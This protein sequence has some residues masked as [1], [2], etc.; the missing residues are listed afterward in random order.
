MRRAYEQNGIIGFAQSTDAP[1]TQ[2]QISATGDDGNNDSIPSYA[3]SLYTL[4]MESDMARLA[5]TLVGERYSVVLL[6]LPMSWTRFL[7]RATWR[8]TRRT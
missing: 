2:L 7:S 5:H 8:S 3:G 4:S 1:H 6:V